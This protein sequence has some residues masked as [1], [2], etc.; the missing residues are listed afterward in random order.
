MWK[1]YKHTNQTVKFSYLVYKSS[2]DLSR[3]NPTLN[4]HGI[5][6]MNQTQATLTFCIII[7]S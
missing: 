5:R 7:P 3:Q 4:K 2:D 1:I 6:N